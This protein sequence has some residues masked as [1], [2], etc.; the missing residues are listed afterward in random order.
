VSRPPLEESILLVDL[1]RFAL[2]TWRLSLHKT[3]F[4]KTLKEQG[5]PEQHQLFLEPA[6]RYEIIGFAD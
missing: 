1:V 4:V 6:Q 3:M 2:S 5:T